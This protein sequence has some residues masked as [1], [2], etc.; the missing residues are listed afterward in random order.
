LASSYEHASTLERNLA[1]AEKRAEAAILANDTLERDLEA[2]EEAA[3]R[4][5]EE[6]PGAEALRRARRDAEEA[7]EATRVVVRA[8]REARDAATRLLETTRAE[9]AALS[10]DLAAA[11]EALL[12]AREEA[13]PG[14][15]NADAETERLRREVERLSSRVKEAYVRETELKRQLARAAEKV[16]GADGA[17][18]ADGAEAKADGGTSGTSASG[19]SA[20]VPFRGPSSRARVEA[21]RAVAFLRASAE[22]R[23]AAR[24]RAVRLLVAATTPTE[25]MRA[26]PVGTRRRWRVARSAVVSVSRVMTGSSAYAAFSD[27]ALSSSL[28]LMAASPRDRNV[29]V[30]GCRVIASMVTSPTMAAHARRAPSFAGGGALRA[31]AAALEYHAA[32]AG[33]ARAAARAM[34]T[35][36]HLGGRPS[37]DEVISARLY[38]RVVAAMVA[39][40]EEGSVL[41]ACC[42]CLLATALGNEEA[43]VALDAAGARAEV[44]RTMRDRGAEGHVMRFGG[45]F[46]SLKEWLRGTEGTPVGK[47]I[48]KPKGLASGVTSK[49]LSGL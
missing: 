22:R 43:K 17:D 13:A 32:D 2:A 9:N 47:G 49:A 4:A 16:E 3:R 7:R 44:R 19:T 5:R 29:Q 34:W 40:A 20:E 45:A 48:R 24:R 31:A 36:V 26:D 37:Q 10:R 33:A 18:G 21:L 30:S 15:A 11:R 12:A 35:A 28:A 42:G 6:G 1:D 46:V 14:T 41:E 27:G 23:Y 25:E 8:D 38:E 39:H